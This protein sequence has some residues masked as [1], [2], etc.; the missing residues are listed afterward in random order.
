MDFRMSVREGKSA[1]EGV[2]RAWKINP[3]GSVHSQA[4]AAVVEAVGIFVNEDP[5]AGG[6]NGT[7]IGG[8]AKSPIGTVGFVAVLIV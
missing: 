1:S 3:F 2:I 8:F 7:E 4:K 5:D 6:A